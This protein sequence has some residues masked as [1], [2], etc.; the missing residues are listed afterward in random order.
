MIPVLDLMDG[1]VVRARGGDRA[2]YAPWRSPLAGSSDPRAIARALLARSP[3][4]TLYLADLDAIR[5]QGDNHPLLAD[6]AARFPGVTLWVDQGLSRLPDR[7]PLPGNTRPV[8]GTESL[9]GPDALHTASPDHEPILSLDFGPEGF[10]GPP[11]ILEDP[12]RWPETVLVMALDRVGADQGPDI[13]RLC[14]LRSLAPDC[15]WFVA[16]GIRGPA[17]LRALERA[18]ARG[19]LVASALHDGRLPIGDAHRGGD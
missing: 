8:L 12:H 18:G 10:R 4:D 3:F 19:A 2:S 16:G 5:G 6:L 17:D 1:Q 9:S 13:D 14:W 11:G 7:D 15:S